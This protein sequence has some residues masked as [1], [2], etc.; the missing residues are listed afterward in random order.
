[1]RYEGSSTDP[2]PA[3]AEKW[4]VSPDGLVYT[5]Y[6]RKGVKFYPSGD[7]FD[8]TVVKWNYDDIL[9]PGSLALT[10]LFGGPKSVQ[11]DH[12][13][14]VDNY[15]VKIFPKPLALFIRMVSFVAHQREGPSL[16]ASLP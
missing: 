6:L 1:V 12:T 3:V 9:R 5:F 13:E 14:I 8:A 4:E 16:D 7:P 10:D 2:K 15:T 11:Y